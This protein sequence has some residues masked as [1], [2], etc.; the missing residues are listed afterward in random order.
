MSKTI[1]HFWAGLRGRERFAVSLAAAVLIS[2][3]L[4]FALIRTPLTVLAGQQAAH[5]QADAQ[6]AQMQSLAAQAAGIR[7]APKISPDEALRALDALVKAQ[8]GAGST[9]TA[10]ADQAVI[11]LKAVSAQNLVEFVQSARVQARALPT[12]VS[13][14]R[15]PA[16]SSA[17]SGAASSFAV[18][19]DGRMVLGLH[20]AP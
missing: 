1:S 2:A 8:L 6:L 12:Q 4:W 17:A 7:A 9:L 15:S 5:A 14:Q 20:A 11:T 19:W 18:V 13:L 3:L 10:S 16:P